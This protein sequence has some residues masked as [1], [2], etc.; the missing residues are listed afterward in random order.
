MNNPDK[1]TFFGHGNNYHTTIDLTFINEAAS[2]RD[3]VREW[4]VDRSWAMTSDHAAIRWIFDPSTPPVE[5]SPHLRRNF[6]DAHALAFMETFWAKLDATIDV[7]EPLKRGNGA[8]QDEIE[9]AAVA[10]SNCIESA[11]HETIPL[12]RRED[13]LELRSGGIQRALR[14]TG[15]SGG[16]TE[17]EQRGT[18]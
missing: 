10:F 8:L 9:A 17:E 12:C 1:P 3:V 11:V 7:F 4:T 5:A 6:K 14:E 18:A 2:R 13:T 15:G 16:A